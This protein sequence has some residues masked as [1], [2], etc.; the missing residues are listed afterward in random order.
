MHRNTRC[1]IHSTL[2]RSIDTSGLC[3]IKD[4]ILGRRYE[5]SITL[6]GD[7]RSRTLNR[8]YRAKDAPTNVLSFPLDAT[9][10]E[11]VLN[12]P[13]IERECARFGLR[14]EGHLRFLLIHGCLHLKGYE[15][16]GTMEQAETRLLNKFNIR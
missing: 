1:A 6:V 10:G 15:H 7:T 14:A 13:K 8:T 2:H 12:V 3:A 5:L 16:G 11:I 4:T 9:H